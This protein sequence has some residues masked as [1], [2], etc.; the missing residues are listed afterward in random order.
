MTRGGCAQT[1]W[2]GLAAVVGVM[3]SAAA[4]AAVFPG[5]GSNKS[6]G[7]RSALY[8]KVRDVDDAPLTID[9][10]QTIESVEEKTRRFYAASSGGQFDIRFD[11]VVDVAL[12]LNADGTRPNQW[13]AKS[14]DYVRDTYGI[15]PEDFHLNLFDVNRT[16]ADPNQGWSGIAILPGNNIAV[17]ANVANSWGQIVVDHELGHRIGTPHSGA[18]RAVNNA[19]YTPYVWDADQNEYA[20]YN[21]TAHGLQPT[22][23]GMQ[24]DSYGNPFSVMGNISHDQFSVKTKHDKFGWLTDQQV[25][26]LADLA[27]GTYRIYAHDELEVVYD[28]ANDAYGV[29]STYAADK[30]YGLQYSR[31]GEQFNP[32]RRRFEP[33]TQNLTLEYRSGRDG[34]Q[35]Y[36]GGAILDLD[37]EGGTNRSGREKELEVGQ[38][39][40]DLD[41]GVS[42][43]WTSADGQDFLSFNPPAPTDPFEL[44]SVWREFSVLGTAADEVGSYIEVAVS[45]VTAG[46]LGDLNGDTLLD[47]FDL[48]LFRD[49][50]LNDLSGLD[51][52]SRRSLGDLDGD[53]RV[54]SDDWSLLRGAFATQGVSVVGGAVVPEPTAAMLLLLGAVVGSARRTLRDSTALDSST[55]PGHP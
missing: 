5:A 31:G 7:L 43:F 4:D 1:V 20:V 2:V 30:L 24:L 37:L 51:R 46:I 50:W 47:Q 34:V 26:D 40:S 33:S 35:F 18:Y 21:S 42:T 29:E 48:I 13:F 53:G 19:N 14:E 38:T 17:Q 23:F 12:Q 55:S 8:M 15:E 44:S 52:L 25:P 22:T 36:L 49:N 6:T 45:S 9:E 16:T 27:D 28:E 41:I 32:D 10:R 54:D 3:A 11:Q 39:L